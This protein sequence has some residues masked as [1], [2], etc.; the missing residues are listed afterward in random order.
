MLVSLK[1]AG[2]ERVVQCHGSFATATC[3]KC[4]YRVKAETIKDDIFNQVI[5]STI[6]VQNL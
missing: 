1:V 4:K 6:L 3:M 2:I 5:D